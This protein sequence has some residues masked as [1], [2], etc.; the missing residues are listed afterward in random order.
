MMLFSC[1]RCVGYEVHIEELTFPELDQAI[2][3]CVENLD[4]NNEEMSREWARGK[5][6]GIIVPTFQYFLSR[7]YGMLAEDV[8]IYDAK[9]LRRGGIKRYVFRNPSVSDFGRR[10]C[11]RCCQ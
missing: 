11:S 1:V 6:K 3:E 10:H 5:F 2:D 7:V 4:E 8:E 9:A